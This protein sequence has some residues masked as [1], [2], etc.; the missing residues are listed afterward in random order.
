MLLLTE[1]LRQIDRLED[2]AVVLIACT[3]CIEALDPALL[4]RLPLQILIERPDL[5]GRRSILRRLSENE[6]SS[7][8]TSSTRWPTSRAA[9]PARRLRSLYA[10]ASSRRLEAIV[11]DVAA[12]DDGESLLRRAGPISEAHWAGALAMRGLSGLVPSASPEIA[13]IPLK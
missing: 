13:K 6:S 12:E 7:S 5:E 8:G 3:N 2:A 1:L 11:A 10:D 9:G 4:R